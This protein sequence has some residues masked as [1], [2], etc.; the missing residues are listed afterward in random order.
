MTFIFLS[1]GT[2]YTTW[3]L[4]N[5]QLFIDY[6]IYTVV[7]EIESQNVYKTVLKTRK[8]SGNVVLPIP[9]QILD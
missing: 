2:K 5:A 3:D 8:Y 7:T 1:Y 4:E 9:Y 6:L